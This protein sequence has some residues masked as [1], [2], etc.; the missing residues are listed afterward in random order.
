MNVKIE[1]LP[2]GGFSVS[3]STTTETVE[4]AQ[5]LGWPVEALA[6][7]PVHCE[8][9]PDVLQAIARAAGV[10]VCV[11]EPTPNCATEAKYAVAG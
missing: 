7:A 10:R 3:I 11:Y 1:C 5:A 4:A 2:D 6:P 9:F 8:T